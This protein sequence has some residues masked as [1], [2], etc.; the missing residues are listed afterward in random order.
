[1]KRGICEIPDG[2]GGSVQIPFVVIRGHFRLEPKKCQEIVDAREAAKNPKLD[3]TKS[4]ISE[5]EF[6]TLLGTTSVTLA[7]LRRGRGR[8]YVFKM[9][10]GKK[11][12]VPYEVTRHKIRIDV[13]KC[14]EVVDAKK[15]EA[16][17]ARRIKNM[18]R[19]DLIMG[20]YSVE[21]NI[22]EGRHSIHLT[23]TV[24][25]S[26]VYT[27]WYNVGIRY[28][29]NDKGVKYI[30]KEAAELL[31]FRIE[32][33]GETSLAE[34]MI[35]DLKQRIKSGPL[36]DQDKAMLRILRFAGQNLPPGGAVWKFLD[37]NDSKVA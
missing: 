34:R 21:E 14:K 36:T 19:L 23:E 31:R 35:D 2:T 29:S 18:V 32:V 22:E 24:V 17:M 16:E 12:E 11:V 26:K 5:D 13:I 25:N 27:E 37:R 4:W 28:I 20:H 3:L 33:V 30:D 1:M 15:S 6:A 10:D 7:H 8:K 9:K